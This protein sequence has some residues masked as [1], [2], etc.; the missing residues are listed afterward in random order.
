MCAFH[1]DYFPVASAFSSAT[2]PSIVVISSS[3]TTFKPHVSSRSACLLNAQLE[4]QETELIFLVLY[5]LIVFLIFFS[6]YAIYFFFLSF[7]V[8]TRLQLLRQTVL[9]PDHHQ[10]SL[11]IIVS[12]RIFIVEQVHRSRCINHQIQQIWYG[13]IRLL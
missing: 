3:T 12:R 11:R 1:Y 10:R 8:S 7:L 5:R 9:F 2:T 4:Q 6:V 13:V